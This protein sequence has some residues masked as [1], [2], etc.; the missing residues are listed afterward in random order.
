MMIVALSNAIDAIT[1]HKQMGKLS[2]D[3]KNSILAPVV[4]NVQMSL[5]ANFRK[6]VRRKMQWMDSPNYGDESMYIKQAIEYYI[7]EADI[8]L[9]AG[10]ANVVEAIPDFLFANSLFTDK[11]EAEK[12]D[13]SV[14]NKLAR[15]PEMRPT[16][17][18]PIYT[19]NDNELK[20]SPAA[21][22]ASLVYFR[23]AKVPKLT[24]KIF[25]EEEVY[26]TDAPDFQD[27]DLH[28]SMMQAVLIEL[29]AYFGVNLDD[30]FALELS[31]QMKQE[32]QIKQQ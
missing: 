3:E 23:K 8:V 27:I 29:M 9:T 28:P 4:S 15:L 16:S 31:T 17:C 12:T 13:M 2:T 25:M 11:A 26:D 10:K 20:L 21:D 1:N 18:L 19:L 14:F 24:T 30:Q 5:F 6:I 22:K 7:S 32:E